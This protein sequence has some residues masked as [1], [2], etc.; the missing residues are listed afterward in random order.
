MENSTTFDECVN[1]FKGKFP[2]K[3]KIVSSDNPE[4]EYTSST[5][6]QKA[7]E[8]ALCIVCADVLKLFENL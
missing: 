2:Q 4:K 6:M 1:E 3:V 7:Q 8:K 5:F